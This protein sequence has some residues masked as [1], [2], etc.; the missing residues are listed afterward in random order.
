[1]PHFEKSPLR[2]LA[3]RDC[4]RGRMAGLLFA[5]GNRGQKEVYFT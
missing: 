1:M 5:V 2:A 3:S 4:L